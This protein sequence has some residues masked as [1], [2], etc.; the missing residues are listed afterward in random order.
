MSAGTI[1]VEALSATPKPITATGSTGVA[2][3]TINPAAK[4]S[5]SRAQAPTSW[6]G[7]RLNRRSARGANSASAGNAKTHATDR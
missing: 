6:S 7:P 5:R 1:A 4:T 2:T 3:A